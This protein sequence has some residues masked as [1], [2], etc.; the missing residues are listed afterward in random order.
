[1]AGGGAA[2]GAAA[3]VVLVPVLAVGG[4]F[5]GINNSKVNSQI[6]IRQTELPIELNEQE[7]KDLVLFYPLAPSPRQ[8]EL[9]Y[10]DS[11]GE[12]KLIVDTQTPLEGLHLVRSPE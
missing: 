6:E 2:A 3:V 1:M 5:R 11:R 4:V 7:E 12:H 10:A 9:T 8:I